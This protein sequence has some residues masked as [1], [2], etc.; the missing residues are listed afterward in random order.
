VHLKHLPTT[1]CEVVH[2]LSSTTYL[3]TYVGVTDYGNAQKFA[4]FQ[5]SA[6]VQGAAAYGNEYMGGGSNFRGNAGAQQNK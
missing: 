6:Q 2:G 1:T 4:T 5:R 3:L